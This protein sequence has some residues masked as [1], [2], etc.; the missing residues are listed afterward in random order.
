MATYHQVIVADGTVAQ[1]IGCLQQNSITFGTTVVP[2]GFLV[3]QNAP[4]DAIIGCTILES[5][6]A[7]IDYGRP[8]ID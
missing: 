1:I 4:I 3:V 7:N 8:Q 6:Q 2:L 5:M